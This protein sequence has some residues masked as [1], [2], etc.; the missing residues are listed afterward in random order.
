[1]A[2]VETT[3]PPIPNMPESTP[4]ATPTSTVIAT[5][6]HSGIEGT[7]RSD[8]GADRSGGRAAARGGGGARATDGDGASADQSELPGTGGSQELTSEH[9]ERPRS[10]RRLG[11]ADHAFRRAGC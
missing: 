2:G 8:S 10:P 7:Y 9:D 11:A 1:M 3:A 6:S 5:S 4:V